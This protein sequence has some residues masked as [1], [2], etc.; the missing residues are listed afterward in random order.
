MCG[1]VGVS[2][3]YRNDG[4][5]GTDVADVCEESECHERVLSA[6]SSVRVVFWRKQLVTEPHFDA[7]CYLWCAGNEEETGSS[8]PRKPTPEERAV[9]SALLDKLVSAEKSRCL[10]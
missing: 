6:G 2:L 9:G 5:N 8:L 10:T 7:D 4:R 1:S 3:E